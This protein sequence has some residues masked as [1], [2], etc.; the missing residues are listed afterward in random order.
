MSVNISNKGK[1]SNINT[2]YKTIFFPP[3]WV[4]NIDLGT[5]NVSD[6]LNVKFQVDD[7]FIPIKY[8]LASSPRDL[9]SGT[10]LTSDGI[11]G[12]LTAANNY[13]FSILAQNSKGK[14]S[15]QNFTLT[16]VSQDSVV[17][18]SNTNL[19]SYENTA[20]V[21]Y[22][23]LAKNTTSFSLM[24]GTL[25]PGLSLSNSG[26]FTGV[27][28]HA[29]TEKTPYNITIR[30]SNSSSHVDKNFTMYLVYP[31]DPPTWITPSNL[32]EYN[33]RSFVNIQLNADLATS[34]DLKGKD[35]L[36]LGLSLTSTGLMAILKL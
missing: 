26:V 18:I 2:S 35:V 11:Y 10:S 7:T 4:S 5:Y 14:T 33:E 23:L 3:Q 13:S 6:I 16:V 27:I 19:G 21:N 30:A 20:H 12:T 17:W 22:H 24:S 28:N 15:T 32:R 25:P 1:I 34:Y 36:P 29:V 9:P 31:T 8:I